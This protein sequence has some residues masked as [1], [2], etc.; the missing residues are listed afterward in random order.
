MSQQEQS[1]QIWPAGLLQCSTGEKYCVHCA[2]YLLPV[3]PCSISLSWRID[4]IFGFSMTCHKT[5]AFAVLVE[6]L[7]ILYEEISR[8]FKKTH[9]R[10]TKELQDMQLTTSASHPDFPSLQLIRMS[11][12]SMVN[13][14]SIKLS[15]KNVTSFNVSVQK[16]A[17]E[18][19]FNWLTSTWSLGTCLSL[20]RL[21]IQLRMPRWRKH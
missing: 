7:A 1:P 2:L 15:I 19:S 13:G 5:A 9:S 16:W 6:Y 11:M 12:S 21:D 4:I 8:R 20:S 10:N 3:S 17:K 18:M 14:Q